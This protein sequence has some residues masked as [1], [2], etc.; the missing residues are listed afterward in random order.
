M[1][2]I[3]AKSNFGA[4]IR[5]LKSQEKQVRFGSARALTA[6][7]VLIKAAEKHEMSDV[8]DRPTPF[9]LNSLFLRA[10]TPGNQMAQ[11]WLKDD[12]SGNKYAG[13][14]LLPQI[15]GGNRLPK[16]FERALQAVGV[17]PAGFVAVPG[18]AA[19]L[20]AY[21]NMDRGQIVQILSYF[22][23]FKTEGFTANITDKKKAKLARGTKKKQGYA[24][25]AGRPGDGKLPLGIWQ[26]IHFARGSAL[27]PLLIFVDG[28][29]YEKRFDFYYVAERTFEKEWP[30]ALTREVGNAIAT[31]R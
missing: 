28:T 14:Y 29:L 1:F 21:G 26:R 16:R 4:G 15:E 6:V 5:A 22:R 10:A 9:T 20:D 18:S 12:D 25:F 3:S 13:N 7:A 30:G 2:S 19:K 17:L 23:A 31:A 8:F 27:K 24:Y 11:V